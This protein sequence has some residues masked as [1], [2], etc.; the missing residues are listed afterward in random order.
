[1]DLNPVGICGRGACLRVVLKIESHDQWIVIT[2]W[3][4]FIMFN[5]LMGDD[6]LG[7]AFARKHEIIYPWDFASVVSQC[8]RT[9]FGERAMTVDQTKGFKSLKENAVCFRAV[10]I[11]PL[12]C[13]VQVSAQNNCR[14]STLL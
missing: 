7:E 9:I 10:F 3:L 8:A 1:M 11:I 12:R 5:H 4:H 13:C 6:F 14:S 2:Q